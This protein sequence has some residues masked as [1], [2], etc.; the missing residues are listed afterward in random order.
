MEI[1]ARDGEGETEAAGGGGEGGEERRGERHCL[2]I[3]M[4]TKKPAHDV[5]AKPL[6]APAHLVALS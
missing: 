2:K 3:L 6:R 1:V 5:V 4:A